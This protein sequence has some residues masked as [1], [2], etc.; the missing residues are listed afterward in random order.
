[1]DDDTGGASEHLGISGETF[2]V[3]IR[4]IRNPIIAREIGLPS[5]VDL[6]QLNCEGC[7]YEVLESI[8]QQGWHTN[9]KT[10]QIATHKSLALTNL[11]RR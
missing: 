5:Y 3:K 10:I 8:I 9:I 6:L 1:M 2:F 4:D 11:E 7:E